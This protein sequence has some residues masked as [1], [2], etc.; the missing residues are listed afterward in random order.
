MTTK[1]YADRDPMEL[2]L[3]GGYY[4][5]H[6]NAMT[7]EGLH[8]KSDIAG[9]LAYRDHLIDRLLEANKEF[10]AR[11]DE[12]A[13]DLAMAQVELSRTTVRYIEAAH[14][15]DLAWKQ[16]RDAKLTEGKL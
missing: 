13:T 10:R 15:R 1:L 4:C 2:D 3:A 5:R 8:A 9:E 6:V 11:N 14:Q 12:L 16:I 7:A